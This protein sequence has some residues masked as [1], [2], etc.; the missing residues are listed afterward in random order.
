MEAESGKLPV[1]EDNGLVIDRETLARFAVFPRWVNSSTRPNHWLC[2]PTKPTSEFRDAGLRRAR[3]ALH[4]RTIEIFAPS[5]RARIS[6]DE[7]TSILRL[8]RN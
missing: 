4:P 8:S 2:L 5:L 6:P 3:K 1:S 7:E